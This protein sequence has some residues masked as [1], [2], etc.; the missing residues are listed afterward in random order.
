MSSLEEVELETS[1]SLFASTPLKNRKKK[2]EMK[3]IGT[4]FFGT[5]TSSV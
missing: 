5:P 3:F 1:E 4:S 2:I